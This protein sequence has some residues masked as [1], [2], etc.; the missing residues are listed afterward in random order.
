MTH[1]ANSTEEQTHTHT[2]TSKNIS[3][4]LS[5][6]SWTD[7]VY[8]PPRTCVYLIGCLSTKVGGGT[9]GKKV[10]SVE[11][12]GGMTINEAHE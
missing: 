5:I 6:N 3:P 1:S 4:P 12:N 2:D 8:P 11:E 7:I 9:S 10:T